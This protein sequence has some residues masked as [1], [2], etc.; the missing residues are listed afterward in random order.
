MIWLSENEMNADGEVFQG[1][2]LARGDFMFAADEEDHD[3]INERGQG[4]DGIDDPGVSRMRDDGAAGSKTQHGGELKGGT[5]E[6]DG[7]RKLLAGDEVR[8]EG[9]I[10]G[11]EDGPGR[12]EQGK[13][14]VNANDGRVEGGNKRQA[15]RAQSDEKIHQ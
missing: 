15:R 1:K 4:G 5:I 14:N 13:A 3:E 12:T 2:G 10:G 8:E 6:G 9:G 7:L 11:P